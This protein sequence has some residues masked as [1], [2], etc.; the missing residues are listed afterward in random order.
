VLLL[1]VRLVLSVPE[2]RTRRLLGCR[3]DGRRGVVLPHGRLVDRDEVVVEQVV[4][5]ARLREFIVGVGVLL[6][7]LSAPGQIPALRWH[8]VEGVKEAAEALNE[9]AADAAHLEDCIVRVNDSVVRGDLGR[10]L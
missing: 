8:T 2:Q 7:Q 6:E 5:R 10:I 4:R 1:L 3:L 9:G